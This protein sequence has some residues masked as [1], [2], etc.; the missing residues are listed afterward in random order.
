MAN[1]SVT[2]G[3]YLALDELLALQRPRSEGPEH[4][5]LLFIVVHQV[6]ELWFKELLHELDYTRSLFGRTDPR[7]VERFA[8]GTRART[9]LARRLDEPTLWD[10]F[11]AYLDREGYAPAGESL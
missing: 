5:E 9:A 4:D 11:L 3:T 8:D 7:A 6:Y 10:G 1:P 2:Y